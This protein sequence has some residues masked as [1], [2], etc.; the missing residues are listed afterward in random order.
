MT[1]C[2]LAVDGGMCNYKQN[3]LLALIQKVILV[4]LLYYE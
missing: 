3:H 1:F 4:I 2:Q